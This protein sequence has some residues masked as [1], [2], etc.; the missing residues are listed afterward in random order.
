MEKWVTQ[1]SHYVQKSPFGNIRYDT[2]KLPNG[3]VID[4]YF[5]NEY[6]DWVNAVVLTEDQQLVLV[7]QYRHAVKDFFLEIPAGK[8]E[9]GETFD[10]AISREVKEETG[11]ISRRNPILLG[12]AYVNPATQTNKVHTY[13][14]TDAYQAFSQDL[15][16][17]EIIDV[18]VIHLQQFREMILSGKVNQ[19]FT[20][21]AYHLYQDFITH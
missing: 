1:K 18:H 16:P 7:K 4:K 5:V 3:Q 9:S 14:I 8:R 6:A 19:L 20:I 12:S 11:Y 13:L 15:D 10:E 2:C 21:H 17:T